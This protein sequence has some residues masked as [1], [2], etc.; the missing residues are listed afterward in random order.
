MSMRQ[1]IQFFCL[2]KRRECPP[3]PRKY[4]YKPRPIL[5]LS[6]QG[7]QSDAKFREDQMNVFVCNIAE[8]DLCDHIIPSSLDIAT[9]VIMHFTTSRFWFLI[10]LLYENLELIDKL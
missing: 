9:L 5:T 1:N 7:M 4:P 2:C 3:H 10:L 8:D 6:P